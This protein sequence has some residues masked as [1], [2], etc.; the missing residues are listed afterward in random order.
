MRTATE[1]AGPGVLQVKQAG[2]TATLTSKTLEE[3][4]ATAAEQ[5]WTTTFLA[6]WLSRKEMEANDGCDKM[7]RP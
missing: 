2:K 3:R 7:T 4:K 5:S 1:V 6:V